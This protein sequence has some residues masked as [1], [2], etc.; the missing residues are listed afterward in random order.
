MFA[1]A[2]RFAL[3]VVFALVPLVVVL[4]FCSVVEAQQGCN[5][6]L[7]L[8][9]EECTV[10]VFPPPIGRVPSKVVATH[11]V[12]GPGTTLYKCGERL[13]YQGQAWCQGEPTRRFD[14]L[15]QGCRHE[16][17]PKPK[18]PGAPVQQ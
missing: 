5:Q 4:S 10:T 18:E 8:C 6:K 15:I 7:P 12:Y 1:T 14:V 11:Q 3:I 9:L 17:L 13:A 2:S 16:P